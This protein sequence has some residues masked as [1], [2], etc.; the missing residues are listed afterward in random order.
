MVFKPLAGVLGVI[1]KGKTRAVDA[2]G[3][4]LFPEQSGGLVFEASCAGLPFEARGSV[5]SGPLTRNKMV[6]VGTVKLTASRG[7]QKPELFEGEPKDVLELNTNG[8]PFEQ[9]GLTLIATQTN[10]EPIEINSVF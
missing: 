9:L 10:E 6:T 5:I 1:K 2:I 3:L 4:D 8:G 7:K